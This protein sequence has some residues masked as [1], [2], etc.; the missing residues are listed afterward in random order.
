MERVDPV[1]V[2]QRKLSNNMVIPGIGTETFG[3]DR[4]Y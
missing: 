3:N 1:L 2:P 4:Q